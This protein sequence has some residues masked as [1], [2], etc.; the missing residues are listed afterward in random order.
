MIK[1]LCQLAKVFFMETSKHWFSNKNQFLE[2]PLNP[3]FFAVNLL[4]LFEQSS[5]V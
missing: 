5:R 3:D 2:V 1:N 4:R